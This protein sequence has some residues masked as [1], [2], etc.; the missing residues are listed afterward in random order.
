[1][2]RVRRIAGRRQD[3][4]ITPDGRVITTAFVIFDKVP[5]ILA[6]QIV[7]TDPDRLIVRVARSPE[8]SNASEATLRGYMRQFVGAGMCVD[9]N[10]VPLE[11]FHARGGVKYRAV[12]SQVCRPPHTDDRV[13]SIVDDKMNPNGWE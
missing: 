9:I 10:Y 6:G 2:P 3:A 1:M 4:I 11:E 7:Q 13:A 8:Y 5:G 12:L